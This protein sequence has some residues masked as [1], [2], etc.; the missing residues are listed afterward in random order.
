MPV[1][2]YYGL[3]VNK[4]REIYQRKGHEFAN[5]NPLKPRINR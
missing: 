1:L 2:G 4:L 5:I 3:D